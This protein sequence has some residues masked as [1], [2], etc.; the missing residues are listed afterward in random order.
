MRSGAEDPHLVDVELVEGDPPVPLAAGAPAP[1]P[2][3]ASGARPGSR[4]GARARHLRAWTALGTLA[5]VALVTIAVDQAE[6]RRQEAQI[7]ALTDLPGFLDPIGEPL[8]VVWRAG[9]G[10]P[11]ARTGTTV[12]VSDRRDRPS[13]RA[14][15]LA[16]GSVVWERSGPRGEV[17]RGVA[18][19]QPVGLPD[20]EH[21][22]CVPSGARGLPV[23]GTLTVLDAATGVELR[24]EVADGLMFADLADGRVVLTTAEADGAVGV[25][26]WDPATGEDAWVFRS[27]AG[28]L[29]AVDAEGGG[30][31]ALR[32]GVLEIGNRERA[33]AL[34]TATGEPVDA[35]ADGMRAPLP[36]GGEARWVNDRFGRPADVT[37]VDEEGSPAFDAPGV[38]WLAPVGDGSASGVLVVRRTS[39]QH[40]L[41]LDAGTGR[42]RW[43]LANVPWLAPSVQVSGIVV[44]VGPT[45]A[46]ALDLG[47]GLRLWDHQAGRSIAGWQALTDGHVVLLPRE[48]ADGRLWLSARRLRT[49]DA[50]W[51]VRLPR[52]ARTLQPVDG[53]TLLV[54]ADG[55]L[56]AL[57]PA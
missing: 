2:A 57:R 16:D 10:T 28:F 22:V 56:V 48:D 35:R 39:D 5:A 14:L 3:T 25:R 31:Y 55:V 13:L 44:G 36:A 27:P 11:V 23:L 21:V 26:S 47:T 33:F 45:S 30:R 52:A 1:A 32:D 6:L 15:D 29:D 38:P 12:L 37:V 20:V 41:G 40:L 43:D 54:V 18:D 46:V 9:A 50:A 4:A 53:R 49:G 19:P 51:E 7:A 24:A 34:A 42:V 8:A 17:C